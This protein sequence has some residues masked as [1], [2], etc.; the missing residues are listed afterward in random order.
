MQKK[1][2]ENEEQTQCVTI[3]TIHAAKGL[4]WPVVF[5]PACYN[6]S[7]PH[8][9][10]D[11]HDEERR[12]LY[13]GMTRAQAILYLSCPT[14][15]S[16]FQET[17]M[18]SYLTQSGVN[19]HFCDHGPALEYYAVSQ[20][21][22]TLRRACPSFLEVQDCK[23]TADLGNL[24]DTYWP[25]DGSLPLGEDDRW[26]KGRTSNY[27]MVSQAVALKRPHSNRR[28]V[29]PVRNA[30]FVSA[31]T[32]TM[33]KVEGFS[34]SA[35][36][37]K[38]S[39]TTAASRMQELEEAQEDIT[40]KKVDKRAA[41]VAAGKDRKGQKIATGAASITNY[42]GQP[43]GDRAQNIAAQPVKSTSRLPPTTLRKSHSAPY[44]NVPAP[45]VD[46]TNSA[47][48][49]CI[50]PP[51]LSTAHSAVLLSHKPRTTPSNMRP[52]NKNLPSQSDDYIF[53]SSSPPEAASNQSTKKPKL[54]DVEE[55]VVTN[56]QQH[57]AQ[58]Q[59]A[60]K[61]ASTFHTTS[62]S[63][64]G[65]SGGVGRKTLGMGRSFKP[66]SARGGKK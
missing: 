15:N 6:G 4:E 5:I 44:E 9:R 39:F 25:H 12:L 41:D 28:S 30:G 32:I 66:W 64:V 54:E 7:I 27:G 43:A 52:R 34:V 36:T 35:T 29:S 57:T 19:A 2:E 17:I 60:F 33:Q 55:H 53:L 20:I 1:N 42:F 11:D 56:V 46:I 10:A 47:P 13:V 18:S 3:S 37:I 8:S 40:L 23:F 22:Q 31:S 58:T 63:Q 59:N 26:N 16:Q 14:K 38:P 24:E 48:Q 45:L 62:M 51:T 61:P 50:I 21:A 49:G 65:M